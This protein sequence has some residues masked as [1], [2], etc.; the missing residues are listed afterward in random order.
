MKTKITPSVSWR[1]ITPGGT[2]FE[3][4]TSEAFLTGDWRSERPVWITSKCR[5]CLL[6]VPVCPDSSIPVENGKRA[7]FDYGHCKGCMIC[8]EV[9]SFGAIGTEKERE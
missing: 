5:Q 2:I 9:C 1:D 7:D 8:A 4:G 6:C 3:G